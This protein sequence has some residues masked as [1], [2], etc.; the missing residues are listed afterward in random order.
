MFRIVL[1]AAMLVTGLMPTVASAEEKPPAT[2]YKNPQCDCCEGY[3]KYLRQNGYRVTVKPTHDL[4]LLNKQH[5]V[6]ADLEG[7]HTTLID[8]YVVEGHV[9]ATTL[10]R[11]LTERPP[12]K[13]ISLPGMPQG[14][15]GMTGRKSGP[16]TIY[17]LSPGTPKVYAVE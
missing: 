2:L 12:I 15:P 16:F 17:E 8:G 4:S 9:P 13:G 6:P 10:D 14:S 5:G 11:L 7:C 3:A 1:M